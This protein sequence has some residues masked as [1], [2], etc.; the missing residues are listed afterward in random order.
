MMIINSSRRRRGRRRRRC[1]IRIRIC[2]RIMIVIVNN[3]FEH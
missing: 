2:N 1:R 3:L